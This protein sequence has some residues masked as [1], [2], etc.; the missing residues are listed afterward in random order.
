[1]FKALRHSQDFIQEQRKTVE[2]QDLVA[3]VAAR[4]SEANKASQSWDSLEASSCSRI[5]VTFKEIARMVVVKKE[6]KVALLFLATV[7]A[8]TDQKKDR[9]SG[10]ISFGNQKLD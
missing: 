4:I 7:K 6:P 5:V 9:Y 8:T 10:E 3:L 1:M 2:G